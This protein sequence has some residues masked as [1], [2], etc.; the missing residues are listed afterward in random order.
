MKRTISIILSL[1]IV[2]SVFAALPLSAFAAETGLAVTGDSEHAVGDVFLSKDQKFGLT[3]LSSGRVEITVYRSMEPVSVKCFVIPTIIDGYEVAQVRSLRTH[4]FK[5]KAVFVPASIYAPRSAFSEDQIVI[6]EKVYSDWHYSDNGSFQLYEYHLAEDGT[7]ILDVIRPNGLDNQVIPEALW[8]GTKISGISKGAFQQIQFVNSNQQKTVIRFGNTITINFALDEIFD[9]FLTQK[10]G[11]RFFSEITAVIT[12]ET[13]LNSD[14]FQGRPIS[15]NIVGD[16]DIPDEFFKNGRYDGTVDDYYDPY[17]IYR[18]IE[19]LS[20]GGG[21]KKIGKK[22]FLNQK[23][24]ELKLE[25]GIKTIGREAFAGCEFDSIE[26]PRSVTSIGDYAL[27]YDY[28]AVNETYNKRTGFKISCYKGSAGEAYAIA[29]GFKPNYLEDIGYDLWVGSTQV[30]GSNKNDILGDGKAKFD[31]DTNTLTLNDPKITGGYD[32]DYCAIYSELDNLTIK[33][34]A[35]I[36]RPDLVEA[37]DAN[38][39]TLSG[40]FDFTADE[41]LVYIPEGY[42]KVEDS[43]LKLCSASGGDAIY[44]ED[45]DLTVTDSTVTTV[46]SYIYVSGN[47]KTE[48]STLNVNSSWGSYGFYAYGGIN[49]LDS[50][51]TVTGSMKYGVF[52]DGGMIIIND[53]MVDATG[54]EAAIANQN[55]LKTSNYSAVYARG[56]KYGIMSTNKVDIASNTTWVE[57]WGSDS[58]IKGYKG[59]TIGEGLPITEPAG[60]KVNGA[61]TDVVTSTGG[62]ATHVVIGTEPE[63]PEEKIDAG[64]GVK[65]VAGESTE[66]KVKSVNKGS[67]TV[68]VDGSIAAAYDISLKKDGVTVQPDGF[69]TVSIPCSD[70]NAKVYRVEADNSLTDMKATYKDG[71]LVFTTDHFSLYIVAAP[72]EGEQIILGDTDGDGSVTILDATYIQRELAGLTNQNAF[73]EAASD[74]DGDGGLSI[75]DATYI[76]RW[77]ASIPSNDNIGKPI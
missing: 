1:L 51:V 33:G 39:L 27:G 50:Y 70:P 30:M 37:V 77:L 44:C 68:V 75:L 60:G 25:E 43:K 48:N 34:K 18:I 14:P 6:Y 13:K 4:N 54:T 17:K 45:G 63:I 22:A 64:T 32:G 40:D 35:T 69:V 47:V 41:H 74:A 56:G 67:I 59:L 52:A 62:K 42:L 65:V 36:N 16:K 3:M 11:Y 26:I 71:Y 55:F 38:N 15:L 20:V 5:P 28:D 8:D 49:F 2:L 23:I 46:D 31:P 7:A 58:A 76:Q 29:N 12:G 21:V 57:A 53:S 19:K 73:V 61:G 9:D 24:K 10:N 72:E 66:L